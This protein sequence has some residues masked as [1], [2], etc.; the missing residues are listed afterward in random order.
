VSHVFSFCS[1]PDTSVASR[2]K[3]PQ[4][5]TLPHRTQQLAEKL[6]PR[7]SERSLRSEE[8]LFPWPFGQEI[9]RPAGHYSRLLPDCGI[10]DNHVLRPVPIAKL[11]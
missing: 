7:H 2:Q 4:A 1:F 11:S 10:C 9:S 3:P 5:P 8:S 6:K